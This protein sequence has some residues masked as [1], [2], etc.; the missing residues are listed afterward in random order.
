M[1]GSSSAMSSSLANVSPSASSPSS[2]CSSSPTVCHTSHVT[3]SVRVG[4]GQGDQSA[5]SGGTVRTESSD[6]LPFCSLSVLT[7]CARAA[8]RSIRD[9][10]YRVLRRAKACGEW[11]QVNEPFPSC[12]AVA[13]AWCPAGAHCDEPAGRWA[14]FLISLRHMPRPPRRLEGKRRGRSG[15]RAA[16]VTFECSSPRFCPCSKPAG[17]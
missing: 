15:C 9:T 10:C 12:G 8:V 13:K 7:P 16:Y 3:S 5:H 11:G 2:A 6:V 4:R 1:L 14:A 17:C